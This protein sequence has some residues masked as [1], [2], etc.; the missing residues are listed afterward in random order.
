MNEIERRLLSCFTAGDLALEAF[1]RISRIELTDAVPTAAIECVDHPRLLLNPAFIAQHC[2]TD[3]HL[4]M[5]VLHEIHHVLL[6]HTRLFP[7]VTPAQNVAFDAVINASLCRRFPEERFRSLF[8]T[9]YSATKLPE[10]FLRP[11]EGWP[12]APRWREPL[13]EALY[14]PCGVTYDE[15][16]RRI[17]ARCEGQPQPLL[18]GNHGE[19][20][21]VATDSLLREAVRRIVETWPMPPVPIEGRSVGG[22]L[23]D[24]FLGRPPPEPAS[25]QVLRRAMRR[26]LTLRGSRQH[27]CWGERE[28]RTTTAMPQLRDRRAIVRLAL[29]QEPLLYEA[30]TFTHARGNTQKAARVYLDISGSTEP[31]HDQ[32]ASALEPFLRRGEAVL[33]AFSEQVVDVSLRDL[34]SRKLRTTQGTEIGCVV[35]HLLH[36]RAS[37][38]LVVTDG[39]VGAV[40]SHQHAR[41]QRTRLH[42]ALTPGGFRGDLAPVTAEF[43]QLPELK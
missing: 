36:H 25:V 8:E 39:Y 29:G 5:L 41:L 1:L 17:A 40:P 13:H 20:R 9:T 27:K 37:H 11:P 7:R 12:E 33:H 28:T 16:L 15:L 3:E 6:G 19:D 22:E 38:A 2:Q 32:L 23:V 14:T 24:L 34:R 21:D 43:F 26:L 10:L 35:D 18:L 42:V 31:W 4:F 30:E